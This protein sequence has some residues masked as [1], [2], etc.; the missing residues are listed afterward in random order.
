MGKQITL[1]HNPYTQCSGT[2]QR[3]DKV[4]KA[5]VLCSKVDFKKWQGNFTN[6]TITI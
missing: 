2:S 4:I 5:R 6:D 3:E 1:Q